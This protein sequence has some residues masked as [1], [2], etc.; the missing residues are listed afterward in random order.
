MYLWR[1][2]LSVVILSQFLF[3]T[4]IKELNADAVEIVNLIRQASEPGISQKYLQLEASKHKHMIASYPSGNQ[5]YIRNL[6]KLFIDLELAVWDGLTASY[7]KYGTAVRYLPEND[8]VV[9]KLL[10][11]IESRGL[12]TQKEAEI[13]GSAQSFDQMGRSMPKNQFLAML[14]EMRIMMQADYNKVYNSIFY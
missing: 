12:S 14:A 3:A 11:E 2:I 5:R 9:S 7:Q 1:V 4:D 8:P 13:P 6:C 10:S